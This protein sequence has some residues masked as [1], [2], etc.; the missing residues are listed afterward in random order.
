MAPAAAITG[1]IISNIGRYRWA[2]WSGWMIATLGAGLLIYLQPDT[3]I[4]G[5]IFLNVPISLGLGI[6]FPSQQMIV[7]AAAPPHLMGQTAAFFSFMRT[8]GQSIG[9]AVS[10]AIFQNAF[11]RK[12]LEV[13]SEFLAAS[14]SSSTTSSATS[15][16]IRS[17][18]QQIP[19]LAYLVEHADE[20]AK[21]ATAVVSVLAGMSSD[22]P[23]RQAL[24][25]AYS[26]SLREVFI[27]LTAFAGFCM[28]LGF[29]VKGYSLKQEHVTAQ[30][31]QKSE[32][33]ERIM[34]ERAR[35]NGV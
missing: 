19:S 13:G 2:I 28:F 16:A 35:E 24:V 25:R 4:P 8:F 14:N 1:I 11:K 34:E 18:T 26:L 29:T 5:W 9:I 23:A 3:S 7:Q 20:F 6:L 27:A 31:L 30:G 15:L 22:D 17:V 32:R 10:S 21:D 33:E 12:L